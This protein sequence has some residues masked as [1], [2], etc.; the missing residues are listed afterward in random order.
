MSTISLDK[1]ALSEARFIFEATKRG[2]EVCQPFH[3]R[4]AYDFLIRLAPHLSW[5]SVQVKTAGFNPGHNGKARVQVQVLRGSRKRSY[6]KGDFDL[7]FVAHEE[8]CW[9]IPWEAI[10]DVT[11]VS[12]QGDKYSPWLLP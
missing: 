8:K 3:Q 12:L 5:Q 10:E 9:L 4:N 11:R 7:L 1:G 6:V 2:W